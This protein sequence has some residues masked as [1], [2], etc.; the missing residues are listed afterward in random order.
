MAQVEG[1]VDGVQEIF[2]SMILK[3][4]KP[5]FHFFLCVSVYMCV[6][7]FFFFKVNGCTRRHKDLLSKRQKCLQTLL[8]LPGL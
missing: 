7:F 2:N 1:H 6:L 3:L 4:K 8:L 5:S